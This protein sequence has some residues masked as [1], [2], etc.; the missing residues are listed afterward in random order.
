MGEKISLNGKKIVDG[1]PGIF[2]RNNSVR[3]D[4]EKWFMCWLNFFC[5]QKMSEYYLRLIPSIWII[6]KRKSYFEIDISHN[7]DKI[8]RGC[9]ISTVNFFFKLEHCQIFPTNF[10]A[11]LW[12]TRQSFW[13]SKIPV[14][15]QGIFIR[16]SADNRFLL[17][18]SRSPAVHVKVVQVKPPKW[19]NEQSSHC[20]VRCSV[21]NVL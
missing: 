7:S 20:T 12:K 9:Q 6:P 11:I 17:R 21:E 5:Q 1:L 16:L 8:L 19:A 18:K 10:F 13:L 2:A 15:N 4:Y 14:E 3:G